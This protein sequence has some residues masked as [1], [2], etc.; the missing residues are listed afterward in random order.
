MAK[1]TAKK[2]RPK[3]TKP[4]IG[5]TVANTERVLNDPAAFRAERTTHRVPLGTG[6]VALMVEPTLAELDEIDKAANVEGAGL[7]VG[8]IMAVKLIVNDAG[9]PVF[10]S[11]EQACEVLTIGQIAKVTAFLD[12]LKD[13]ASAEGN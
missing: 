6:V 5:R 13:V 9:Q 8:G 7:E 12:T 4:K 2:T 1:T 10:D 11:V 3:K